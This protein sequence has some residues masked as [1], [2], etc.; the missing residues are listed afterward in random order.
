MCAQAG[1]DGFGLALPDGSTRLLTGHEALRAFEAPPGESGQALRQDHDGLLEV[2]VQ[3]PLSAPTALAGR[4]RGIRRSIWN[5]LGETLNNHDADTSDALEALYQHP[6]TSEADRRLRRAIRNGVTDEDL[7]IRI[8]ALHRDG[9][10]VVE[11]RTGRDPV[12]IV[13]SMGIAP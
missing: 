10:L 5:R 4:L 11:A 7:A 6:L 3:G 9:A 13:S 8:A 2:M 1:I 12:R